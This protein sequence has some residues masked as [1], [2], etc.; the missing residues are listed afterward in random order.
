MKIKS[1]WFLCCVFIFSLQ[2]LGN[3]DLCQQNVAMPL[4][5]P[6][7]MLHH[8]PL[9]SFQWPAILTTALSQNQSR[10]PVSLRGRRAHS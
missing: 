4:A 10:V 9:S 7:K 3:S 6:W 5:L 1:I 8:T 2:I